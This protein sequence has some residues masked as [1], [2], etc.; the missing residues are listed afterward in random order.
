MNGLPFY[1][2]GYVFTAAIMMGHCELQAASTASSQ[3]GESPSDFIGFASAPDK[4]A[5]GSVV[6]V[7]YRCS[8]PCQ[9]A[10]EVV[11]STLRETDFAVFRRKWIGSTSGVYRIHQVPLGLP[12][13]VLYQHDFFNRRVLRTLNVTVRAWLDH[14]DDGGEPGTYR[15]STVRVYKEL[16]VEPLSER[17]AKPPTECPSWSAQLVWQ[18]TR[19]RVRQCPHESDV[20]DVLKFP[21]AS[22]GEHFGVV[23]RFQPF[24]DRGLESVRLRAVT[25]PS[26]TLSAWVYLLKWCQG[27]LCG[28]VHH[29]GRKRAYDSVLLQLTHTGDVIIQTRVTTGEDRA[30][31]ANVV[32]PR[33]KWIRLDCSIQDS[34]VLLD[35]TWDDKTRRHQYQFQHSVHYDDTDGYFVIGG[36]DYMPGI[37]GYFGPI[38]YYRLGTEKVENHLESTSREL[39]RTHQECQEVKALTQA[40]LKEV[41][42]RQDTTPVATGACTPYFT[43]LRG[44]SR[45]KVCTQTWTW[46]EQLKHSTLFHLL[47]TKKENIRTGSLSMKELRSGLFD[48]AVGTMFTVDQEQNKVKFGST[49]LLQISSCIGNHKAS[50]LLAAVFFSGLGHPVDQQQG[51]VYSLIGA[52]GDNRFALMHAGYKH[53]QG[54]DGFPKDLDVAYSYYSNVGAQS[55]VD[56]SRIH[57]NVQHPLE[58]IYVSNAEDLNSFTEETSDVFHYLKYRAEDGDAE[59]QKQLAAMLFWGRH[60]VPKD[61]ATAVKWYERSALQLEDPTAM[62]DYSVLLMKGQGVKTNVTRGLKLL[63]K[64]AAMGSVNALNGLGWYYRMILNDHEKAVKYFRQAALNGSADAMFNLGLHHLSHQDPDDPRRNETAM[65]LQF[66]NASRLGHDV[67]SVEAASYLSTGV[68]EG[69]PQDVGRA[70]TMVKKVCDQNG[71]LGLVVRDALQDYIRGSR[72]GA[73]VKYVLAAEAGLALAQSNAAHLCEELDLHHACQWRYHNFSILNYDPHPAALL[74]MGDHHHSSSSRRGDSLRWPAEAVSMYVRAAAA[75]SPQGMFN[76][77]LLAERGH[78]VPASIRSMFN[79]SQRDEHDVLLMLLKR[80]VQA[81]GEEAVMPC[82]L[83]LLRVQ[84]GRALRRMSQSGAQLLLTYA[85]L[86]SVIVT[87]VIVPLQTCL[88]QRVASRR[89]FAPRASSTSRGGVGSVREQDGVVGGAHG[90]AGNPNGERRLLQ[91]CDWAVSLSGVCLCAFCTA[92]LSH[93]L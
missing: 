78:V 63:E 9:L 74:K 36:S 10:V 56:S 34:K 18:T 29:V 89:V 13:S 12:P 77:V 60:G 21:L 35:A 59:S 6:R 48:Q 51:H 81:E 68:L 85:S 40:F 80:C 71:H 27:E 17:P 90:A 1:F 44:R 26:V 61:V 42:E 49:A 41:T 8:G 37:H 7:R 76:L 30:F 33:W 45:E 2:C 46:E 82:S 73:F 16:Q 52:L 23:R 92:I 3:A 50:L 47:Q 54:I 87:V 5:H 31:R 19:N 28:I 15:D 58:L 84:M 25:Q 4:V 57:D 83:A 32:L 39:D 64:A 24:M 88:E 11:V 66:L 93:L 79:E 72:Q 38:K 86:L 67:A 70:V 20:I 14:L 65:V 75:G 69:V 53:Q 43:R 62:Y 55:I 22:P 91:A